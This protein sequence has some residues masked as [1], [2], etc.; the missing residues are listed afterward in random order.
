MN[1]IILILSTHTKNILNPK[2]TSFGCN[3][4]NKNNFPLDGECLTPKIIYRADIITDNDHI[5]YYG[6]SEA[7]F[8]KRHSNHIHDFAHVKYQHA[9]ELAEYIWQL[10][11]NNF[12]CSIKWLITS[13]VYVHANSLL[14]KLCLM[15][16]YW[17]IKN[18][19]GLGLLNKK[20]ELINKCRH[21]N[22]ILLM[23]VKR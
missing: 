18:F 14:C 16:K 17:I 9:T 7:T 19:D 8:K 20:L 15:E 11:S 3:C 21:Q 2:L 13:K 6:T 5:F 1:N 22:K 12:N 23:N 4:R 10:K